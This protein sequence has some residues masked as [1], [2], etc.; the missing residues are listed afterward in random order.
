[1]SILGSMVASLEAVPFLPNSLMNTPTIHLTQS[2]FFPLDFT[3]APIQQNKNFLVLV[4][5]GKSFLPCN[6]S[7]LTTDESVCIE[8]FQSLTI[9][10][11]WPRWETE[12]S[13]NIL[14]LRAVMS[15]Q[16]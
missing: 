4:E 13:S 6:F 16:H 11:T 9:Q 10:G 3:Q 15:F 7:I 2:L 14:D 8:V 1:M 12:L 5:W